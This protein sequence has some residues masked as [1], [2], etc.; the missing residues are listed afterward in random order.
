MGKTEEVFGKYLKG[1]RGE[2]TLR[3]VEADA[4]ISNAFLSQLERGERGI[5]SFKVLTRLAKVYGVSASELIKKAEEAQG[6]TKTLS[7]TDADFVAR[8]LE[9][10]TPEER[11]EIINWV[12][13]K[14]NS[15]NK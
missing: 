14:M 10:L 4:K 5:P 1:L 8:G 15:K 12:K 6:G 2:R 11:K 7:E 13:Y 9:A 3:D